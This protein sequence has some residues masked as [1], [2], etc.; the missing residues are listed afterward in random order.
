MFDLA[1]DGRVLRNRTA[2]LPMCPTE[3]C[4]T[5]AAP[6]VVFADGLNTTLA[7]LDRTDLTTLSQHPGSPRQPHH[8]PC[9]RT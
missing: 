4:Q 1:V 9:R 2:G 8:H 7:R 3:L 6:L 5:E